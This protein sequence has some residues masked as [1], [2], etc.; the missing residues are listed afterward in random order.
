METPVATPCTMPPAAIWPGVSVPEVWALTLGAQTATVDKALN[1][2][3][4]HTPR[5]RPSIIGSRSV[6]HALF[7]QCASIHDQK[8]AA[9]R[10]AGLG[11]V[12]PASKL[13]LECGGGLAPPSLGEAGLATLL[14][15]SRR[16]YARANA[17][18]SI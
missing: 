13:F 3:A 18:T 11:S 14:P 17:R 12:P 15:T 10:S 6:P 4:I 9:V 8:K 5:F 7:L 1:V 2:V 16:V